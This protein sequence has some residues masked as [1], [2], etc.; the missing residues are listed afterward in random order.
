MDENTHTP[1]NRTAPLRTFAIA[2]TIATAIAPLA[3]AQL[4]VEQ[5][6][7]RFPQPDPLEFSNQATVGDL[8][9][10]GDLDIIFA[11]G[12]NFSTPGPAQLV[13]FLFNDG[14][15]VFTDVSQTNVN[16]GVGVSGRHRGAELGDVDGDGDYDVILAPDFFA[17]PTLLINNG[18]GFFQSEPARLP[19]TRVSS[20]RANFADIDNDGDLDLYITNGGS[21]SRF[22]CGQ[23]YI[24]IN[25]G[26]G[27]FT[28]ETALRHPIQNWCEP[29]DIIFGDVDGDFDLDAKYASTGNSQ[30]RVIINDG[31]GVF[32]VKPSPA[33]QNCYSYDFGDVDGDGDLDLFGANASPSGN[34]SDALHINDGA[35]NYTNESFRLSPN[36]T[37]DD[38]DSKFFDYDN[39]GD[40]DLIVA[41]LGGTSERIYS[42]NGSGNFT[43]VN[44]LITSIGDSS[45]DV[46][47]ADVTGDGVL[48]IIT[49]QGESGNFRNRLYVGTGAAD[50]I[51]P[52]I[53]IEQVAAEG[54]GSVP[55]RA[56]VSDGMTADRG[57]LL[58]SVTL[59]YT[60]QGTKGL[61]VAI[62]MNWS[63]HAMYRGVLP[64]PGCGTTLEYWVSATDRA[65]NTGESETLTVTGDGGSLLGD[66]DE[67]GQVDSD[68]LGILLSAFG[69][70][71][72]GDLD[73]DGD[74]DSDDLGILLSAFGDSCV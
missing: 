52:T 13:R 69:S 33:D 36:P 41:R 50:T 6:T 15:G 22:G 45:L 43:Q 59:F 53:A 35:G 7:T 5:S 18:S 70:T 46:M 57:P 32:T 62:D 49:A 20:S 11:N 55:V 24:Y 26:T 67:S 72:A 8:D 74:T 56:I 29:M 27:F 54:N 58:Q 66:L 65:G 47:V 23:Q 68:D 44:G 64:E 2:A 51:A 3:M 30:G 9:G 14:S 12:G 38:N 37:V 25:D 39:D 19:G 17:R 73:G 31:T 61:P 48:D 4:F 63:G 10:D 60:I 34:N 1:T 40:L 71:D 42:N 28:D 16:L 21:T